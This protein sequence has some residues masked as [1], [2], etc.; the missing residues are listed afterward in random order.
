[1]PKLLHTQVALVLSFIQ[2]SW[3]SLT[4]V[5]IDDEH[6]DKNTRLLPTYSPEIPPS[7]LG[8]KRSLDCRDCTWSDLL[9]TDQVYDAS[10]HQ[11][12]SNSIDGPYSIEI[13]FTGKYRDAA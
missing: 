5:T 8:W 13:N 9:D 7:G 2:A 10:W 11:G 1:M 6:G 12:I 4:N 3:C